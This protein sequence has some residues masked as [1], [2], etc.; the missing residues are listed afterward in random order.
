MKVL[1]ITNTNYAYSNKKSNVLTLTSKPE[2]VNKQ[3][4]FTGLN[5]FSRF[6]ITTAEQAIEKLRGKDSGLYI[7]NGEKYIPM[8]F[9]KFFKNKKIKAT[10]LV[11]KQSSQK[12][13]ETSIPL[14]E[15]PTSIHYKGN[16]NKKPK[17]HTK[18]TIYRKGIRP[19][20]VLAFLDK[21]IEEAIIVVNE[22]LHKLKL[23]KDETVRGKAVSVIKNS[24][25][26]IEDMETPDLYIVAKEIPNF[27]YDLTKD[28]I[29]NVKIEG[30]SLEKA[31][32]PRSREMIRKELKKELKDNARFNRDVRA[33]SEGS[34]SNE[35]FN[36]KYPPPDIMIN[37][38]E[39]K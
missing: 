6:K 39:V 3:V 30:M 11:A 34:M 26:Y 5:L 23:P 31:P 7:F 10:K 17:P 8:S 32:F 22:G 16:Y 27:F 36:R 21:G 1:S 35:K 33:W 14:E 25:E 37:G 2:M 15:M 12:V 18:V 4:S 20:N 38:K 24:E 9:N 19:G 13:E 29:D 28:M